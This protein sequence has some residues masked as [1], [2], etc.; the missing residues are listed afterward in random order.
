MLPTN[1]LYTIISE[2]FPADMR[3]QSVE[4]FWHGPNFKDIWWELT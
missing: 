4:Y 1:I 3:A 2:V